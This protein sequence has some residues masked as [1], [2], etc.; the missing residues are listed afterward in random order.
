MEDTSL[1]LNYF[2]DK[3]ILLKTSVSFGN[4]L[5]EDMSKTVTVFF[6]TNPQKSINNSN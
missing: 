6:N 4:K 5:R 2:H 3:L 1:C